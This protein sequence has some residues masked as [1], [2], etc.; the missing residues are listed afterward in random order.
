MHISLSNPVLRPCFSPQDIDRLDRLLQ[1]DFTGALDFAR[2]LHASANVAC[3]G[4][5]VFAIER[6]IIELEQIISGKTDDVEPLKDIISDC[7]AILSA[8]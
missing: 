3:D 5:D 8:E 6:M 2:E 1:S 7:R 4:D